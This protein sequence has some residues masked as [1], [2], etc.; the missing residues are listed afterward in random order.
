MMTGKTFIGGTDIYTAFG[1]FV[2]DGGYSGLVE[3][4]SLK[5]VE[6]NDWQ[7]EDGIEP[8]LSSPVLDTKDVSIPFAFVGTRID[9]FVAALS[10]KGYH[11]FEFRELGRTFRLRL[12]SVGTPTVCGDLRL[13]TMTFADDFPLDG[14]EYAEPTGSGPETGF[15]LDGRD[16]SEYGIRILQGTRAQL[17]A[18]SAVKPALIRNINA[19]SGAYYDGDAAVR[20]KSRNLSLY[21]LVRS[22]TAQD[23]WKNHYALLYDLTRPQ[24][25]M[26]KV[27]GSDTVSRCYYGSMN[28]Q[29]FMVANGI[30][31]KF[32]LT[33]I[34]I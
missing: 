1:A 20:F 23:F 12:V 11:S 31:M 32:N 19:V 3:F 21:C 14:Y 8:D 15:T 18:V 34:K 6:Y 33:L 2:T 30:W 9:P 5:T 7:E 29:E 4:P 22:R 24:D 26:L 25:R 27:L 10:D 28:V 16:L 13:V 17:E